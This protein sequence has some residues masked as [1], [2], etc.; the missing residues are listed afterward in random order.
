[1]NTYSVIVH[2]GQ[3]S[4][5]VAYF[6]LSAGIAYRILNRGAHI[7]LHSKKLNLAIL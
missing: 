7:S 5:R 1:M 6:E 2:T 4:Q 3:S